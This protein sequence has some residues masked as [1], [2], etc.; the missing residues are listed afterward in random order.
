MSDQRP[1]PRTD[2]EEEEKRDAAA[3]VENA[4]AAVLHAESTMAA[5]IETSRE[6]AANSKAVETLTRESL[7]SD[8]KKFRRRN[9]VLV[10]LTSVVIVLL[11]V[12]LIR[13][14]YV[15]GPQRNDI[16]SIA[17]NLEECTTPGPRTPT[18]DDPSTGHKCFDDGQ[19]RTGAAIAA[20]VDADGN[21]K[22]DTQEIL[23][24]I[25][26]FEVYLNSPSG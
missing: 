19:A 2:W 17:I 8:N 12:V 16:E 7:I 22:V 1:Y 9:A 18:A 21:G 20:I 10:F 13:E 14:I 6:I 24:A 4:D 25:K 23:A 3:A 5:L 11:S 26:K 15:V